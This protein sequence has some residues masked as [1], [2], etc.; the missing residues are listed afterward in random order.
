MITSWAK[1]SRRAAGRLRPG[2]K[3]PRGGSLLGGGLEHGIAPDQA[4]QGEVPVQ[5]GPAPALVVAEPQLLF[6]ILM[7]ALHAPAPMGQPQLRRQRAPIQRT[8]CVTSEVRWRLQ[9]ER[10]AIEMSQQIAL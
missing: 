1:T 10:G 5:P 2:G 7:E 6:P 4:H 8:P 3:R 9:E